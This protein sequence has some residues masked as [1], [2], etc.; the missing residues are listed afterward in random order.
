MKAV[1]DKLYTE[2]GE[3]RLFHFDE[4]ATPLATPGVSD[5]PRSVGFVGFDTS[6]ICSPAPSS[7]TYATPSETGPVP[8]GG[9]PPV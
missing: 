8:F 4:T 5:E 9:V 2:I 7:P 1:D 6:M 3:G